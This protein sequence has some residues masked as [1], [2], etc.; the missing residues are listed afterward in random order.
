MYCLQFLVLAISSAVKAGIV[1]LTYSI[2]IF[3]FVTFQSM[4]SRLYCKKAEATI[5]Y[6]YCRKK[7]RWGNKNKEQNTHHNGRSNNINIETGRP[8]PMQ[9][10]TIGRRINGRIIIQ[11]GSTKD[12][13]E[14][15]TNIS[16]FIKRESY[17]VVFL[18]DKSTLI[19]HSHHI[20]SYPSRVPTATLHCSSHT[21]GGWQSYLQ[22]HKR[23]HSHNQL[24]SREHSTC[25]ARYMYRA[26]SLRQEEKKRE[27][28][29]FVRSIFLQS[30]GSN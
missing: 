17:V 25:T 7:H 28:N 30:L 6:H 9:Q 23:W 1:S 24:K 19:K 27:R 26:K 4:R 14:Q 12:T 10:K 3:C 11:V 18:V 5:S 22:G 15:L 20:H 13:M 16:I 21:K 2:T 29:K 8:L